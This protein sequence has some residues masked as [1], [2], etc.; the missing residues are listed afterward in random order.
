MMKDHPELGGFHGPDVVMSDPPQFI[1]G[2]IQVNVRLSRTSFSVTRLP[3]VAKRRMFH[4]DWLVTL[5]L[6][7]L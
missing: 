7:T 2:E 6:A 4:D 5:Y 3:Y 1:F